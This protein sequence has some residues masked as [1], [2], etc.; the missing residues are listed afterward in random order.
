MTTGAKTSSSTEP[1]PQTLR[2]FGLIFGIFLWLISSFWSAQWF[3]PVGIAGIFVATVGLVFP[4]ALKPLYGPWLKFG[5]VLGK[6]NITIILAIIY[7]LIFTPIALFFK[8]KGRDRLKMARG[9][10]SYWE[11]YDKQPTTLERYRRLF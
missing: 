7:Y 11:I 2:Y 8:L 4:V 10:P 3:H 5:A 6:I 1:S 9:A